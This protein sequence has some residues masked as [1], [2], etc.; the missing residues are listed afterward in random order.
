MRNQTHMNYFTIPGI[1][2]AYRHQ[3]GPELNVGVV[4]KT[5]CKHFSVT[6]VQLKSKRRDRLIA[7]PR[8]LA[9][10]YLFF[11]CGINKVQIGKMFNRDHTTV[12]HSLR[13]IR[14]LM[15][16]DPKIVDEVHEVRQIIVEA[17]NQDGA[18][19]TPAPINGTANKR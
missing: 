2:S 4:L 9:M 19:A 1:K 8:Q 14:D 16:T 7:W 12:I 15:K 17:H 13:T 5:V 18:L 3:A 6:L 10:H 11:H